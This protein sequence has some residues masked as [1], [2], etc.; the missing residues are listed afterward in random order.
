MHQHCKVCAE[1][2]RRCEQAC[3]EG[4]YT[5]PEEMFELVHQMRTRIITSPSFDAERV[6]G[7]ILFQDTMDRD[8][9]VCRRAI[10]CGR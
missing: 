4:S 8:I 5:G 9:G 3:D 7:A 2:C 10:T 1:A 6:L